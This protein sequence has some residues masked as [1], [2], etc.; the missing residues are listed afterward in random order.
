MTAF[1][2][3]VSVLSFVIVCVGWSCNVCAHVSLTGT[4]RNS[5][6]SCP[7]YPNGV[8]VDLFGNVYIPDGNSGAIYKIGPGGGME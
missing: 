6:A 1:N 2:G 8:A 7:A 4:F 5:W 3:A